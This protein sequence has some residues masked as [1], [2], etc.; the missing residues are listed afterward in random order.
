MQGNFAGSI[1]PS[2]DIFSC[3]DPENFVRW[4]L[5]LTAF[6]LVDEG[7]EDLNTTSSGPSSARQR[8]AAAGVLM[9]AQH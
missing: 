1:F 8:F 7:C 3:A 4:G 2:V 9:M 5:T 6:F